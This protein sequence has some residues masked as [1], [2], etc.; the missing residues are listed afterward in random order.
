MLKLVS[1]ILNYNLELILLWSSTECS[2]N[3][4]TKYLTAPPSVLFSSDWIDQKII[5][6]KVK[7]KKIRRAKRSKTVDWLLECVG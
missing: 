1:S 4:F 3:C 7:N 5:Y 6:Q 2:T